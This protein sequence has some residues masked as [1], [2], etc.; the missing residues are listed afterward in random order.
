MAKH[1]ERQGKDPYAYHAVSTRML[2]VY[3]N[4]LL[5]DRFFVHLL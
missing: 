2:L 5:Y 4:L 3:S 1:F